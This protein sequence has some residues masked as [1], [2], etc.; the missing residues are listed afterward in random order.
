MKLVRPETHSAELSRWIDERA[1][2]P[3][4]SSVLIEVE[5]MRAT[6]RTEPLQLGRAAEVL[7]G[8]GI[9]TLSQAVLTRAAGYEDPDLRSLDAIHLATAEHVAQTSGGDLHG[10]LGY[11]QRL[12]DAA[13]SI[14]LPIVAPGLL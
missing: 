4:L 11:D 7:A 1:T 12:L 6:R 9:I 10:F 5:L 2:I 3:F 13:Q 8:I 14:G